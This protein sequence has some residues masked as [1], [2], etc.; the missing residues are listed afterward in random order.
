MQLFTISVIMI[1]GNTRV[2]NMNSKRKITDMESGRDEHR[3]VTTLKLRNNHIDLDRISELSTK[4]KLLN[5]Q[6]E[7][8]ESDDD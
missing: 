7:E 6:D 4:K 3:E 2:S 5:K 8:T 1:T